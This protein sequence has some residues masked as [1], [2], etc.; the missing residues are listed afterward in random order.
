VWNYVYGAAFALA[1]SIAIFFLGFGGTLQFKLFA[2]GRPNLSH[3]I[4]FIYGGS[5]IKQKSFAYISGQ[6]QGSRIQD[7]KRKTAR[8]VCGLGSRFMALRQAEQTD[9]QTNKR[10]GGTVDSRTDSRSR[11]KGKQKAKENE[12]RQP[13]KSGV[14]KLEKGRETLEE[15]PGTMKLQENHKVKRR[16]TRSLNTL[17][18]QKKRSVDFPA[19]EGVHGPSLFTQCLSLSILNAT[20]TTPNL[21]STQK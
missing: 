5:P 21:K 2:C 3:I 17:S 14:R 1:F 10:T 8:C 20:K 7:P 16:G 19:V 11:H 13:E 12:D 18:T 6:E 4:Y 9:Q 15:L